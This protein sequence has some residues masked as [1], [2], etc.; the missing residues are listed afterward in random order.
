[1]GPGRW[2]WLIVGV[3][4]GCGA[5]PGAPARPVAV[6]VAVAVAVGAELGDR[7]GT[8]H[9]PTSCA[10]GESAEIDR[11]VA[12][13]HSFF[14]DEARRRFRLVAARDPS[15]AMA[16]WG[17]AMTFW[18]PLWQAPRPDELTEG[19][20]AI[21]RA[22][23]LGPKTS[24]EEAWV[25]ALE[26]F[27]FEPAGSSEPASQSCHGVVSSNHL[28]GAQAY[29]ARMAA[30]VARFP[31]DVDGEVFHALALLAVHP[32]T[33]V[34]LARPRQAAATLE[35]LFPRYP[36][37]PGI[38]HYLIHAYDFPALADKGLPAARAYASM[39]P[40]V[41]HALH[42]P[43]HIFTRLGMWRE[44]IDANLAAAAA[45][46]KYEARFHPGAHAAEEVH[47]LD[48]LAYAYLQTAQDGKV[49][50]LMA[51]LDTIDRT[52]PEVD[53]VAG[54]PFATIPARA[55]LERRSWKEAAALVPSPLAKKLPFVEANV[56]Y[57]RAIGAARSGDREGA[58]AAVARLAEL[59]DAIADPKYAFFA[60][61]VELQRMAGLAWL[62]HAEHQEPEALAQL[63]QA[64]E[65]EETIGKHPVT[66]GAVL[67]AREQLGELLLEQGQAAAALVE[68]ERALAVAPNRLVG[69]YGAAR[70]AE[71]AGERKKARGYY[72][73]VVRVAGG[74]DARPE[75]TAARAW[76]AGS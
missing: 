45:A 26:A 76:L 65:L 16:E 42:M 73:Q 27:Y 17:V 32:P 39:A 43:S 33:D 22:R 55:A 35:R 19:V 58:R 13:L 20:A 56:V 24:R 10:A 60:K 47:A 70:A 1:M 6:A 74:G 36:G 51:Y 2:G 37:H 25:A 28:K 71:L 23:A 5:R 15:C 49:K 11:A 18:H 4:L 62:L 38:V 53:L 29:E 41:P 8:T 64:A 69:L 48:Y 12:L 52:N 63:R 40:W 14:Y 44:S 50:A 54:Y 57:A 66:P 21:R 61:Q 68:H 46:R 7:V 72:E 9:F 31:D 67:P 75:V 3:A 34:S 30:L 59:R